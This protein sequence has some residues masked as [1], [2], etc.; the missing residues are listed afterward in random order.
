[1][2]RIASFLCSVVWIWAGV[3]VDVV[4][5]GKHKQ[6]SFL[7]TSSLVVERE[8]GVKNANVDA[9]VSSTNSVAVLP[10]AP[11][12]AQLKQPPI[13]GGSSTEHHEGGPQP[14][15]R[16]V[17][18]LSTPR[19][20]TGALLPTSQLLLQPL[21]LKSVSIAPNSGVVGIGATL[22]V[23]VTANSAGLRALDHACSI[24]HV[25]VAS[26]W[27]MIAPDPSTPSHDHPDDNNPTNTSSCLLYTSPSPRDRG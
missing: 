24:N 9:G 11:Q 8:D 14:R 3:G 22:T 18:S 6:L 21:S 19:P 12:T 7:R 15:D 5:H 20:T 4:A 2:K 23:T 13:G 27:K 25:Q 17:P 1:M 16:V 26:T 10:Q